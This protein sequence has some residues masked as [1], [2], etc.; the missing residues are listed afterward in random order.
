MLN[1]K[2]LLSILI[3]GCIAIMAT[4]GTFAY[5][6]SGGSASGDTITTGTLILNINNGDTAVYSATNAKP[7]NVL[8]PFSQ[9]ISVKN[10]GSL[11]GILT[12]SVT[13]D[14]GISDLKNVT[15]IYITDRSNTVKCLYGNGVIQGPVTLGTFAPGDQY[16]PV[17][18]YMIKDTGNEQNIQ[19]QNF[20]FSIKYYL[21]QT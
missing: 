19:S 15:S 14:T 7:T 1:K 10:D 2:L 3:I 12:A 20:G 18:S 17:V 4:A 16:T 9:N 11:P 6:G 5:F 13:G 8:V 21:K